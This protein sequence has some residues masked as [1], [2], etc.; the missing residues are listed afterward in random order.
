MTRSNRARGVLLLVLGMAAAPAVA[1]F[2]LMQIEKVIAGVNG[3]TS[4]Q[5][6]VLRMRAGFQ[7]FVS[8]ARVIA[9]DADG[10]NPVTI[11]DF[12]Q[13]VSGRNVVGS[14]LIA[15]SAFVAGSGNTQPRRPT[16]CQ[17]RSGRCMARRSRAAA[18]PRAEVRY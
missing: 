10:M 18:A 5:A 15:G 16:D 1:T 4:A 17:S 3:D 9:A 7:N 6:I 12:T 8:A 11:I 14:L 2:H 13:A